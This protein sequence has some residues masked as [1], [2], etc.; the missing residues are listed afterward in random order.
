MTRIERMA[1]LIDQIA[2][3]IYHLYLLVWSNY[4]RLALKVCTQSQ[5]E[6]FC[7][8]AAHLGCSYS[9][10]DH[11]DFLKLSDAD[12]IAA[13]ATVKGFDFNLGLYRKVSDTCGNF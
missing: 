5:R 2:Q 9:N 11:A 3:D 10:A 7:N 6:K 13:A 4:W 8:H 1:K 12:L